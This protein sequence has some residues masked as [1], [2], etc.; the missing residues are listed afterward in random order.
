MNDFHGKAYRYEVDHCGATNIV[1]AS[2]LDTNTPPDRQPVRPIA[3]TYGQGLDDNIANA[4]LIAAAPE[5]YELL[6]V[7]VKVQAQPTLMEA[8]ARAQ[9][10]LARIDGTEEQS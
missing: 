8:R 4:R 7:W 1:I 9:E 3:Q 5:M 2:E 10:L 6:E